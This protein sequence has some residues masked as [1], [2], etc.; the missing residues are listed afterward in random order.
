MKLLP[1][2]PPHVVRKFVAVAFREHTSGILLVLGVNAAATVCG[3]FIPRI[4]GDL[5][6]RGTELDATE[7]TR[8]AAAIAALTLIQAVLLGLAIYLSA[9]VGERILRTIREGFI[10]D[11]LSVPLAEIERA[12]RG[13][14]IT[15]TTRDVDNLSRAVRSAVPDTIIAAVT[16]IITL[17]AIILV[18]PGLAAA[19]LIAV[20]LLWAGT[21]WYLRRARRGYLGVN[22]SYSRLTGELLQ[23][24]RGAQTIDALGIHERRQRAFEVALGGAR[25]SEMYTLRLRSIYLPIADTAYVLP[26]V[27]CLAVG[28]LL[29]STGAVGIAAVTAA[30]LYSQQIIEPVDRLLF[31]L[32]ELQIA[33]TSVARLLGVAREGANKAHS[34]TGETSVPKPA[35]VDVEHVEFSYDGAKPALADVSCQMPA[36]ARVSIVGASGSGKSTLARVLAGLDPANKGVVRIAG[37]SLAEYDTVA[38][39]KHLAL[40]S[41]EPHMFRESII[42]NLSLTTPVSEPEA[43]RALDLVGAESLGRPAVLN[44][45]YGSGDELSTVEKQQ[46]SLARAILAQPSVLILDEATAAFTAQK[47][48]EIERN[49]YR[50]LPST[51]LISIAHRLHTAEESDLVLV[52]DSGRIVQAGS[53]EALKSADG[54]YLEMWRAWER[55]EDGR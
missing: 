28:G 1:V 17:G 36:G 54:R 30:V 44:A 50:A 3:I 31:W 27:V 9:R 15:R 8:N 32:D 11:V 55:F 33:S 14:L 10:R 37:H 38:L 19:C 5:V 29:Y 20:P 43:A 35:T 13:D 2:A 6:E 22:N 45:P 42:E 18:A 41:Q 39:R 26:T 53:H 25:R 51:T 48:R 12:D 16:I 46:V 47:S 4:L 7:I 24:L 49:L 21:R 23:N 52:M 40:V 34:R